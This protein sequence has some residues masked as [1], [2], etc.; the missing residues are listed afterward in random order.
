MGLICVLNV[1]F[2]FNY[3]LWLCLFVWAVFAIAGLFLYFPAHT[4]LTRLIGLEDQQ[5]LIFGF[6][7]SFCGITN[8]IVN[9]VALWLLPSLPPTL[10]VWRA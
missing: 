9:F 6:T 1:L 10:T 2:A 5:G 4:K 3:E 8:V 7:E